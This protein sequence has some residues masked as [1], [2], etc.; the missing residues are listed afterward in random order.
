MTQPWRLFADLNDALTRAPGDE[1]FDVR[2]DFSREERA[3]IPEVVLAGTKQFNDVIFALNRLVAENGRAIAS[4]CTS[5]TIDAIAEAFAGDVRI[6][7]FYSTVVVSRFDS[8]PPTGNGR[9]GILTAGA[10]DNIVA[11]E[12]STLLREMGVDVTM[13]RDVGVAG[14][15]RI[16]APLRTLAEADVDA[17]IVAAGMDGALPSVIAGL[18]PVAVIGLPVSSGYGVGGNGEAALHSMLQSC[19]PGLSVVNVDNGIGAAASAG[20]IARRAATRRIATN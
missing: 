13:A 10:S 12:A 20:L 15:H 4:R 3:G 5:A 17:I 6:E 18:V 1:D 8:H 11:S 19:A 9:V 16:V 14:L 2:L 7:P